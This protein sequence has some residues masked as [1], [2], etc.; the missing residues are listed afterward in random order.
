MPAG[1]QSGTFSKQ[2]LLFGSRVLAHQLVQRAGTAEQLTQSPRY[3][4]FQ[5]QSRQP[6]TA[7]YAGDWV[8]TVC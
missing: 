5:R 6:L 3:Q 8:T 1:R 7:S 2:A 4:S